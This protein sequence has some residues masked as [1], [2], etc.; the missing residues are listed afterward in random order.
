MSK[1][2]HTAIIHDGAVLGNDV[3][4]G[5]YSIIGSNVKISDGV[6]VMSH[7]C[8]DGDTTVGEGSNIF[9]FAVI[10]YAPPDLKYCGEKTTLKIGKNT[11]IREHV[12]VHIG[13]SADRGETVIGDNCLLMAGSHVAHD[14][15]VGNKVIMA[16]NA[17]L[18]GHVVLED[19]V[20]VGGLSAIQQRMHIGYMSMIGGMTGVDSM[21]MPYGCAVGN[22]AHLDGVNIVG[23]RRN[24]MVK[25]DIVQIQEI[26]N[27]IFADAEEFLLEQRMQDVERKYSGFEPGE[28]ILNF[29]KQNAG[30]AL[31]KPFKN[32]S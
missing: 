28:R 12:T 13:T 1:I 22:R 15:V 17:A 31:C 29:L 23:M 3:T 19:Q 20:I 5:A 7:V 2:H 27:I 11:V 24:G 6:R 9:P 32:E 16:N 30:K 18:G 8:I 10:G 21:L 4:I 25:K 26:Y 14:C